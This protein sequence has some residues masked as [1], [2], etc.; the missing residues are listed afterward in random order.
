MRRFSDR[1]ALHTLSELN[2]TPLLDLAFVL[3]IIFMITTPLLENSMDLVV[4]SSSTA[5]NEINPTQV[6]TVS[7]DRNDVLKLNEQVITESDLETRLT[8]LKQEQPGL[9]VVV[10]PHRELPVQNFV[11]I[12]DLLHKAGITK[13]GV[14]TRQE[15]GANQGGAA[16]APPQ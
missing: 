7:I 1:N 14:M 16:A 13:V 6:Q 15:P 12:M 3:L 4:P 11:R 8:Q 10:R 9:A 5:R 2:V